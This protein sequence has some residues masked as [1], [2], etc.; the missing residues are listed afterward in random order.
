MPGVENEKPP[1]DGWYEEKSNEARDA[2]AA[3]AAAL[4]LDFALALMLAFFRLI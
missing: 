3:G 4:A 1:G 2:Y